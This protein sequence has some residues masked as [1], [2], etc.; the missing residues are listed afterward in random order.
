MDPKQLPKLEDVQRALYRKSY[1]HFFRAAFTVLHPG[2]EY[3]DNWHI[4]AFCELLQLEA[5]RISSNSQKHQDLLVNT[6]F[7]SAKSLIFSV[8]YNAWVWTWFPEAKFIG[9]SYSASL[10]LELATLTRDLISS[11]W[12]QRLWGSQYKMASDANQKGFYKT[13]KGGFRKSVGTGGQITG[14]GADFIIL[15]DPQS[16]GNATSKTDRDSVVHFYKATLYSRLNKLD[17][18]V[19]ICVQ[20]RLHEEDLTGYLLANNPDK[21][22]HVC[23]PAVLTED[24]MPKAWADRYVDGLFWPDRFTHA[25]LEDYRDQLGATQYANQLLQ[26]PRPEE[27]GMFKAEWLEHQKLSQLQFLEKL[28]GRTPQWQLFIDGAETADAKNDATCYLLACKLDNQLFVAD[29]KWVR[30]IFTDLV[31]DAK[32]YILQHQHSMYPISRVYIE[33]KSVG[34]HLLAQLRQDVPNQVFKEL[35]PGRDSKAVRAV[36]CQPFVEGG[37]VWLLQGAWN[38]PFIDEVT[39]FTDGKSGHDDSL[40][41]LVYAI[42]DTKTSDFYYSAV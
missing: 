35:Q 30:K 19:R 33:G 32:E 26:K 15:D 18:G 36:A 25:V 2:E 20:Q 22:R 6:P 34:K 17:V 42:Q 13:D 31:R 38:G 27:G 12:Y 28:S 7:R 39:S 14:S 41:V 1:Y 16:P 37:R 21:Y 9:V 29:V 3:T 4:K 24:L 23:V 11:D 40:D 10:A 5:E 8:M